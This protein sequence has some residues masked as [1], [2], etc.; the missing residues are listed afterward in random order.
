MPSR[1]GQETDRLAYLD[2]LR[3][4]A[5]LAVVLEH[6]LGIYQ[7]GFREW[8]ARYFTPGQAGVCLFLLISGFIV[9]VAL[10]RGG[11]NVRFW[12]RRFWRLFPLYWL[13]IGLAALYCWSFG[14][15]LHGRPMGDVRMWLV[16]LTMLQEFVGQPHVLGLYWTLTLE[17]MLYLG[18][19][20]CFGLGL[21]RRTALLLGIALTAYAVL[22]VAVLAKGRA[23]LLL[24]ALVGMAVQRYTVGKLPGRTLAAAVA[25]LFLGLCVAVVSAE[26]KGRFVRE[27]ELLSLLAAWA[28]AYVVFA[29][30]ILGRNSWQP[31]PLVWCGRISYSLYLIHPLVLDFV[32]P[33]WLPWPVALGAT[34]AA[35]AITYELVERPGIALG[36]ALERRWLP[37]RASGMVSQERRAAV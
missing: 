17:L 22:G 36:S 24:T 34:V 6:G 30:A 29:V 31:G 5:A 15:N 27:F 13:S 25:G 2:V 14:W 3:A 19:S 9:P 4:V 23:F 33:A 7:P 37:F 20:V 21:L 10:E 18:W 32:R 1:E 11:S 8:A 35:A 26:H 16:N 28:A 12:W